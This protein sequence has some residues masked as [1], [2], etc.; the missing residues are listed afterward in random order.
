MRTPHRYPSVITLAD[1]PE[2]PAFQGAL[3]P[4]PRLAPPV[5]RRIIAGGALCGLAG[6]LVFAHEPAGVGLAAF[7]VLVAVAVGGLSPTA[8]RSLPLRVSALLAA[9]VAFALLLTV[10]GSEVLTFANTMAALTFITLASALAKPGATL[11]ITNARVRDLLGL[12]PTGFTETAT[13]AP[14]FLLGDARSAFHTADGSSRS[15]LA[16]AVT[17]AVTLATM[18]TIVFGILLSGGDPVFRSLVAWPESWK[19]LD[20]PA[21]V[22]RFG[23][24]AWPVL[25]LMWSTTR[26]SRSSG[27]DLLANGITLNRLD[28]VS[29]LGALNGLFGVYLLLQIRVLFGGSAYVLE[30]TGLTLAQYARDGF[31]AL[32]FAAFLV[33]GV[34][35]GLNAL[36]REDRLGAWHVSRRMSASLV[37]MVGLMLVSATTRMLLYVQTF[38][39]SIDRVIALAIMAWV[40]MVGGWF[41]L[42]VLRARASRF[43]VGAIAAGSVTLFA[44]NVINPEAI[45]VESEVA[46]AA[47]T[48]AFDIDYVQQ[49][50]GSDGVPVLLEALRHEG[51]PLAVPPAA[52]A[53]VVAVAPAAPVASTSVAPATGPVVT[54]P[55]VAVPRAFVQPRCAIATRLLAE[56]GPKAPTSL[57]SLSVSA[58]RARWLVARNTAMLGAQCETAPPAF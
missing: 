39:I 7:L 54:T 42:T 25:G 58:A 10:R 5:A 47:R 33:L 12:V 46:R 11:S 45:V 53:P 44:L 35:L 17:R 22:I 18:L 8:I 20:V 36:L 43:V 31:F 15:A 26:P 55:R 41:L 24:F 23:F 4:A 48:G 50:I 3:A 21:H 16:I 37:V 30:T 57:A 9:A 32:T 51:I 6:D 2:S 1:L 56:W 52:F 28:V 34:L 40:A 49:E 27:D 13:G 14:R 29:T 19:L 38:G